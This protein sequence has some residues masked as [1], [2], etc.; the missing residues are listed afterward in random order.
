M[1]DIGEKT[2]LMFMKLDREQKMFFGGPPYSE[3]VNRE[4]QNH[5]SYLE[6]GLPNRQRVCMG[7]YILNQQGDV[8]GYQASTIMQLANPT[9]YEMGHL[10]LRETIGYVQLKK[11][12]VDPD[13]FGK[14]IS[15]KLLKD[16]IDLANEYNKDW[17]TDVNSSNKRMLNFTFKHSIYKRSEWMTPK[18]TL[19]Y[20]LGI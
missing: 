12:L 17:V 2:R 14:G 10:G 4:I 19:M 7:P 13:Y 16:S 18:N 5:K 3:E 8:I 1:T 9:S 20:R 15:D 11:I 6:N